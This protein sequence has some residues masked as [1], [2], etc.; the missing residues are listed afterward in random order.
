MSTTR[1]RALVVLASVS[2]LAFTGCTAVQYPTVDNPS[3]VATAEP[4]P[5]VTASTDP[6]QTVDEACAIADSLM[7]TVR[8]QA[9]DASKALQSGDVDG[10]LAIMTTFEG[11]LERAIDDITNPEVDAALSDFGA[12]FATLREL[13][14][15]A[16]RPEALVQKQGQLVA[17]AG[18]LQSSAEAIQRLCP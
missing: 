3:P 5:Q 12:E 6:V 1:I 16:E 8:S 4:E 14:A 13:V 7:S 15:S 9:S 10:A 18:E 17:I 11:Q 2:I